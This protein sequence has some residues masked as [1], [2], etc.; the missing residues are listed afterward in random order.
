MLR[1]GMSKPVSRDEQGKVYFGR[2]GPRSNS[3]SFG[4]AFDYAVADTERR[5]PHLPRSDL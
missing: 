5:L 1:R 4:T 2:L 3:F